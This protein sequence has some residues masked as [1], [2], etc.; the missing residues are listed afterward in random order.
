[1]RIIAQVFVSRSSLSSITPSE[2]NY[3]I[4]HNHAFDMSTNWN[5]Y[6]KVISVSLSISQMTFFSKAILLVTTELFVHIVQRLHAIL[7]LQFSI[8]IILWIINNSRSPFIALKY[9]KNSQRLEYRCG[10]WQNWLLIKLSLKN[11]ESKKKDYLNLGTWILPSNNISC[12]ERETEN[13]FDIRQ[14]QLYTFLI[15]F[16]IKSHRFTVI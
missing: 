10:C 8:K 16:F 9:I 4:P 1:M 5:Q 15:T 7:D 6:L 13:K 3:I 12:R 14:Y 11:G 2:I